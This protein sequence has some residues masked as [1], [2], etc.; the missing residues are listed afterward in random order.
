MELRVPEPGGSSQLY[1]A[2][3]K[4][5]KHCDHSGFARL[6]LSH[7]H[8]RINGKEW[9]LTSNLIRIGNQHMRMVAR[10]SNSF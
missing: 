9:R 7:P 2:H 4:P 5:I 1:K 6:H 8:V 10:M 3:W